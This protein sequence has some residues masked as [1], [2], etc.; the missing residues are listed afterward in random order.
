MFKK[1][2]FSFASVLSI[3]ALIFGTTLFQINIAFAAALSSLSDTQ[4]SLKV[5]TLSDHTIQF[6]TPTGVSSGGEITITF[7]AGY[8]MGSFSV[9]NI[10]IATSTSGT[11]SSFGDAL[12]SGT[13]SGLTWGVAQA[14]QVITLTAGSAGVPANR[15]IQV[16]IGSNATFGATGVTQITNPATPGTYTIDL[17]GNFGDTGY[18]NTAIITDDTVAMTGIVQQSLTFTVSTTTIYFGTLGA[19]AAKYA[20]STNASG[21]TTETIAHTVAVATN[22]ASGFSLTVRG[23]TLT[24]QQNSSNTINAIGATAASSTPGTEQFALRATESGGSNVTVDDTFRFA[25]SYG[26]DG[27]ATTSTLLATGSGSTPTS[28][29]SL[30]YLANIAGVTEAGTYAAN[31]V[32]V[33]TANF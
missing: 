33:A 21:D 24:S 20:S 6:V 23:Q 4:S 22:A 32:Y 3:I 13:Q 25:T 31:L 29:L 11:C 9:N 12:V 10:D 16:E 26:Y 5:N 15:C 19:G 8:T 14:G 2:L 18:I 27:T 17:G 7:P 28:T 1:N 30:R